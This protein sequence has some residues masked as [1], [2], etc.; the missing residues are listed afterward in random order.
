MPRPPKLPQLLDR[1]I[2]KTGQTRGADDDEIYQ[3]RVSRTST[4]LVPYL[5]WDQVSAAPT[6]DDGFAN[7]F[8]A[9]IPPLHYFGAPDI[10]SELNDR[11]LSIGRNA[12]V[13]YQTRTEWNL[14]NPENLGWVP[15]T[16]RTDPLGGQYV[17]RIAATTA[18]V[19]GGQI[20]RGFTTTQGKGAGIRLFEYAS[21]QAISECRL[22]LEALFWM[23][24]DSA[25]IAIRNGMSPENVETRRAHN[26]RACEEQGLLDLRHLNEARIINVEGATICPLCLDELSGAGFFSRL[27]QAEGRE[28]HDLTVTQLNLFHISELRYGAYNHRPYNLGW[29]HHHCNVVVKD[30]GIIETLQWMHQ[31]VHRNI[32]DG[33]FDPANNPN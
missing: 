32:V 27:E 6:R 18:I 1:K 7:G 12:L 31:V 2:Y 13:F 4:V 19:D 8:I 22:Q 9:L 24:R 11:G 5:L 15:A 21:E 16:K 3:N 29:G 23:C 25:E 30:S 26:L 17:A 10:D 28:V 20:I 33:H 14:N